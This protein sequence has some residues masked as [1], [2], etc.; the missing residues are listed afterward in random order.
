ME[1][2]ETLSYQPR[3]ISET[4]A[5]N[6]GSMKKWTWVLVVLLLLVGYWWRTGRWPLVAIV[7]GQPLTRFEV[8]QQLYKQGGKAMEDSLITQK[9]VEAELNKMKVNVDKADIDKRVEEMRATVPQGSTLEKELAD[10]GF[11]LD[12]VR[13]LV[14]LQLRINKALEP[15]A[16]VSAEEVAKYIKDNGKYMTGKTDADKKTEAESILK[17]DKLSAAIEQWIDEVRT[18]G[19]VWKL[20]WQ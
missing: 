6:K 12:E 20:P 1:S 5:S 3:T 17:Q 2:V 8:E 13:K 16:T 4:P 11:T 10:K 14:E 9:L 15:K 7:A 19:K 18:N